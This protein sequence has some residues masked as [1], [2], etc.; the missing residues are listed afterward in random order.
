MKNFNYKI[1]GISIIGLIV[2]VII[3]VL[4]LNYFNINVRKVAQSPDGQ[5]N[6]NY[7]K[8]NTKSFVVSIWDKYVKNQIISIWNDIVLKI[9][10]KSF[11]ENMTGKGNMEKFS[12]TV[13]FN[14]LNTN[15][16]NTQ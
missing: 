10:I 16:T 6:I 3:S 13:N 7:I 15:Q 12:P 8:D 2:F 5:T 11:V 4:I 14:Q 9:F 1:G